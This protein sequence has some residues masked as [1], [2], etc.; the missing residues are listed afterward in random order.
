AVVAL[1]LVIGGTSAR[2]AEASSLAAMG[3]AEVTLKVG[4]S[5]MCHLEMA[6]WIW[7]VMWV[8]TLPALHMGPG[9]ALAA[10]SALRHKSW[11]FWL[12]MMVIQFVVRG[13][14][15]TLPTLL[16]MGLLFFNFVWIYVAAR[17]VIGGIDDN[18][19]EET[20][21]VPQAS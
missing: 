12:A 2:G 3:L 6:L 5:A 17:E 19:I 15:M 4:I 21:A 9:D 7:S 20:A 13:F 1:D 11:T 10:D 8:G 18:G 14:V 16:G